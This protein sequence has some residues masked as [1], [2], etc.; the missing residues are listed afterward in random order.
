MNKNPTL[1][2]RA[3]IARCTSGTDLHNDQSSHTLNAFHALIDT[4]LNYLSNP[5]RPWT[6][7]TSHG[8]IWA[9]TGHFP[10]LGNGRYCRI[11]CLIPRCL[12]NRRVQTRPLITLTHLKIRDSFERLIFGG[13][14]FVF[15]WFHIYSKPHSCINPTLPFDRYVR[16]HG[17]RQ[18][19][20]SDLT[21]SVFR[22]SI[23]NAKYA[24]VA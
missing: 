22:S 3:S 6:H 5:R 19:V 14:Y 7:L 23:G 18:V 10:T 4:N 17:D 8:A 20:C 12:L 1:K 9:G 2:R 21:Q 16:I 13:F 15:P 24:K 11:S